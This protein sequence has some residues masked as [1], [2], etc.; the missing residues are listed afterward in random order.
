MTISSTLPVSTPTFNER[1]VSSRLHLRSV[2]SPRS[3]GQ[4]IVKK[5]MA[6]AEEAGAVSGAGIEVG[7]TETPL[8]VDA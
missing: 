6:E 2:T 1:S 3:S 5:V 8:D 7:L 4:R